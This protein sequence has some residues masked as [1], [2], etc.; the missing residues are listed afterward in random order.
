MTI[1]LSRVS[2]AALV[3]FL[4]AITPAVADEVTAISTGGDG[5][6]TMCPYFSCY[7]YHHIKLPRRIAIGDKVRVRFGSNPKHYAFPVARI[8]RDGGSCTIFSQLD[9]TE[10]VEKIEPASCQVVPGAQ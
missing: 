6:L 3:A 8:V 10:K 5:E 7:L 2:A 1:I 9:K 4:A